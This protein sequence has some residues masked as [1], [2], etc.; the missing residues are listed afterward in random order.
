HAELEV[1]V[2][3]LGSQVH[4]FSVGDDLALGGVCPPVQVAIGVPLGLLRGTFLRSRFRSHIRAEY[5]P[6]TGAATPSFQVLAVE[7]AGE[8]SR[9]RAHGLCR[10][11]GRQE[12]GKH[13]E[14]TPKEI[15]A[16]KLVSVLFFDYT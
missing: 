13:H 5:S 2:R 11:R 16:H 6:S 10:S 1:A 7:Q 4:A 9:R 3:L 12:P 8:P 15:D 14:T